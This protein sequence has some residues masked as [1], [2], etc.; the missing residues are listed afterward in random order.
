MRP[1]APVSCFFSKEQ[2]PRHENPPEPARI[3]AFQESWV[4]T[5]S[6][7]HAPLAGHAVLTELAAIDLADSRPTW[8]RVG[9]KNIGVAQSF[10]LDSAQRFYLWFPFKIH[11]TKRE[12]SKKG[13][14]TEVVADAVLQHPPASLIEGIQP[15]RGVRLV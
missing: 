11:Q 15:K 3:A 12:A 6:P 13:T 2:R 7:L 1:L 14:P 5:V 8:R 9:S 10:G 4:P